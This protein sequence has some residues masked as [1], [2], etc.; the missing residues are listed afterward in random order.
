MSASS[1]KICTQS[2]ISG[3]GLPFAVNFNRSPGPHFENDLFVV[4]FT[5]AHDGGVIR[6][7]HACLFQ[8][9]A[10]LKECITA[11]E[12]GL[13]EGTMVRIRTS[14][15]TRYN[16]GHAFDDGALRF[17]VLVFRTEVLTLR[18][19]WVLAVM[20]LARPMSDCI[21]ITCCCLYF[22]LNASLI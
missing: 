15:I 14:P 11:F 9:G 4:V 3:L 17:E 22:G 1:T 5:I 7:G 2:P 16:L 21:T 12:I 18:W 19:K 6:N 8:T 20:D 10:Q 13:L